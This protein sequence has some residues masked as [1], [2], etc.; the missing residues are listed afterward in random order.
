MVLP[1]SVK[2]HRMAENI[3]VLDF[4]LTDED[5][6]RIEKLDKY[7]SY[8]TNPNPLGAFLGG[9]DAYCPEGTDIFD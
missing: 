9:K 1:K 2:P 3:N 6:K 5:M 7:V 4:S 8:K